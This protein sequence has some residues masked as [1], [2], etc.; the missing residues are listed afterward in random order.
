[1]QA[2]ALKA[3]A[4][5]RNKRYACVEAFAGDIES[6]QNGFA[7][8]AEGAGV[9]KRINL[10][11]K[12]N[13]ATA[14]AG[15]GMMVMAS[16]FTVKVLAEGR[17]ATHALER[18]RAGAPTFAQRAGDAIRDGDLEEALK[19]ASNA[20][21]LQPDVP[22]FHRIR[23]N[24]LQLLFRWPEAINEYQQ[25]KGD[26]IAEKN[27]QLTKE[28]I[29]LSSKEGD[30]VA[31]GRLFEELNEQGRRYEAMVLSKSLGDFWKNWKEGR[32]DP[33]VIPDLVGRLEA[34][35]LPVPG[36]NS[37]MSKTEFTVGEWKLYIR[38]EGYPEWQ[39][40]DSK[41]FVQTDEHPVVKINWNQA[42]KL[43]EWLSKVTGK[44]WG[45]PT[46]SEWDAAVG[47]IEYHWGDYYPPH[48]DDGNFSFLAD[49]NEDRRQIGMDGIKGTAPV[50]SFK[51][52]ALGFYDLA[53]NAWEWIADQSGSKNGDR[54]LRGAG[55]ET[56]TAGHDGSRTSCHWLF[57][58]HSAWLNTGF[59]VIRR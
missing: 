53:G 36:T 24:A 17:K 30:S 34:K 46:N 12:R 29:V 41:M 16:V 56:P 52:N 15:A 49:G 8:Q 50:G 7:T 33:S 3:M 18:L 10:W 44:E 26:E 14:G 5:D 43:C 4:T 11:V 25:A 58:P 32:K 27:L 21:D 47:K 9:F 28:L 6:Y 48:W 55:W 45:L 13:K 1:L 39:Q 54:M 42:T 57:P 37:L 19:A 23:G 59:R 20:V 40:P 35:L 38:A 31:K 2:V 22:E 51:P